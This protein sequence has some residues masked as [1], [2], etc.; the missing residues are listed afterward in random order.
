MRRRLVDLVGR[1][2]AIRTHIERAVRVFNGEANRPASFDLLHAL[3]EAQAYR[4]A[5]W[6]TA[7][8]EINYRRFFDINELAGLRMEDPTVFEAT[9]A[10]VLRLVGA[11]SVSGFRI[12][13]PDGLLDPAGYFDRLQEAS[14]RAIVEGLSG[15]PLPERRDEILRASRR[16]PDSSPAG[17]RPRAIYMVAEKILS[18]GETL[19]SHWALDGTTGY[20]FLNDVNGLFIDPAHATTMR[21]I[22]ARFAG[23]RDSFEDIVYSSKKVIMA[24]A[25]AS[26][27]NVLSDALDRISEGD[28]RFRDF[29]LDGLRTALTEVVACFP[30]YR[31]YLGTGRGSDSDRQVLDTAIAKAR[32]RNPVMEPSIFRFLRDVLLPEP[33]RP[34]PHAPAPD[35]KRPAGRHEA[36]RRL[37]LQFA[38]R[39]QQYTGPVQAKGLEDTAFYRYNLLLF[40]NEVGGDP[41]SFGRSPAE[42]HEANVRRLTHW[43][44]SMTCT[45]THD[46]KR[47]ED[48]RARLDVLTEIPDEWQRAVSSWARVN[49]AARTVVDG[50]A[51]PDRNDEYHFYQAILSVWP[52]EPLEAE[53]PGHAPVELVARLATHMRKATKEAKVHTSWINEDQA[54]DQAVAHFVERALTGPGA[55]RFLSSFVPFARRVARAGAVNSLAQVVLKIASPGVPDFYQGSELWD[56]SL[57]DP[58]N[59]QP[60]DYARRQRMLADLGPLLDG[61]EDVPTAERGPAAPRAGDRAAAVVK[62]LS[63]WHDGR[64][65]LLVTALGLRLRQRRPDLLRSGDYLPLEPEGASKD[66]LVAFGRRYGQDLLVVMVPRLAGGLPTDQHT[67]PVGDGIWQST[68]VRLPGDSSARTFHNLFTGE[69]VRPGRGAGVGWIAAGD[70]LRI[71]PVAILRAA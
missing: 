45:A 1:S 53:L 50:V 39:L 58:D 25:M 32:L 43:P 2:A 21:R 13:H 40:L 19:P 22:Y 38:M 57:V 18:A 24:T 69:M 3:L 9:H 11:G 20:D 31:T 52:A 34:D 17:D 16:Q 49:A 59:R 67:W 15:P 6:R 47:G 7:A 12:D 35:A 42:F 68:G 37:R 44:S 70:A 29:T 63:S 5:F 48:A 55:P 60:I 27:L 14:A 65:K 23:R 54:Y 46:T 51:A 56:L 10:L 61:T 33:R 4:L 71:C 28:R 64:I 62:L 66:H 30:V 8:E 41:S 36:Q 26:E